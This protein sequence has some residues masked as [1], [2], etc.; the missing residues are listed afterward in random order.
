MKKLIY[1]AL[2]LAAGLFATSC[3][4]ELLEPVQGGSTVTYTVSLP[5]VATKAIGDGSQVDQL[6][7][8]VYRII[9]AK[10]LTDEKIQEAKANITE[11]CQLV[12]QESQNIKDKTVT[13][14]DLELIKNQHY[15][16]LFWAQ[17]ENVWFTH[18]TDLDDADCPN[19]G[20]FKIAYP[21]YDDYEPNNDKYDAFTGVDYISVT[22]SASADITLT[23]PFG[24]LNIATNLPDPD[25]FTPEITG[26]TVTVAGAAAASY[27]VATGV[28]TAGTLEFKSVVP[29]TSEKFKDY[30]SYL[31]MNYVFVQ[32]DPTTVTVTY[33]IATSHGNVSN[34]ITN[35]PVARNYKTNIIGNLLTSDVDYTVELQKTWGDKD[36]EVLLVDNASDLQNAIDNAQDNVETE[37][38]LDG[39][40]NL[41]DLLSAVM[42]TIKA[43]QPAHTDHGLYIPYGKSLLLDLNGCKISQ[44][45]EQ[46]SNYSMILVDGELTIIDTKGTGEISYTDSG[47]GGE[48][49]SNTIMNRG[50]LT[51]KGGKIINNSSEASADKGY[52][53]AVDSGVWGKAT[54]VIINIEGGELWSNYSPLRVRGDSPT[55][56]VEANI[57]GGK[58]YGRID[59]QLSSNNGSISI[60]NISGGEFT[61]NG[62]KEHTIK[63]FGG[64]TLNASGVV[65]N[66]TGGKFNHPFDVTSEGPVAIGQE[67]NKKFITGGE[68]A[69]DPT[70]NVPDAYKVE[71]QNGKWVVVAKP[72]VAM[73]GETGYWSLNAA[74][75]AV[76]DGGTITLVDNETFTENNRYNNGGWWDGL[77]YSG[78]KSFTIDLCGYT[79]S[80][81]G[82]LNDYLMWFKNDG[83]KANT[84]TL[85]NG[86]MDAGTTAYCALCTS[87]SNKQKI[88]INLEK[89]HL[90]NNNS[91]GATIKLRAGAELNVKAGTIITGKNSYTGIEAVGNTTIVNIYEGAKIY[92]NGTSS[93]WGFLAGASWG[94][95]INVYGGE[96]VSARGGFM[97]MTSGGTINVA[98]GKWI[99]NTDGTVGDN[100]NVY[101]LTAQ[102]NKYESGYVGASII[103]VTGGTFR[104]G[105]DAWILND[106]NVE[107]AELNIMG[108]N[109]NANPS[110]YVANDYTAVENN[111][112]WNVAVDPA[113]K[114]GET[115]YATLQ[116]ALNV[117]GNV[118]L[119]RDVNVAEPLILPKGKTAL[120]DLNGRSI[121]G[122]N[123]SDVKH[124]YALKN[125]GTLTIVDNTDNKEGSIDSRGIYNYNKL[126]LESGKISAID[127]NGGYAVNNQSGS[128]FVMNG[129][130]IAAD[131]EDDDAPGDGYDATALNVPSGAEATLNAGKITNAGNF[132]Y[133]VA[134]AGTLNIPET[135]T[136]EI[137]GRHGAVSVSGGTTTI[138]AGTY[139]IVENTQYSDNVLYVYSTGTMIING[140]TFTGDKDVANGGAC[141]YDA[142]GGVIINGGIFGNSSGGDVWGTTGTVIKG[143]KFEN[144]TE[145]SHIADGYELNA[146]GEVVAK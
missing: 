36:Y 92:Q 111:G 110:A 21:S 126:T 22:S 74:V 75:A 55:E 4:Q 51:V 98:G 140:G 77:G 37:I 40:I 12:Y 80:Q 134:A 81:D 143:G 127:G 61:K 64:S 56:K 95:T 5:E 83:D 6:V 145:T 32:S 97:A 142:I 107:K 66:I 138:N 1:C 33:N 2:A 109:F 25:L 123:E 146:N 7:Y 124:I 79:I 3:Q 101:V 131:Y 103:N 54:E 86:T 44:T 87:S 41:D 125:Y 139:G 82:A 52:M 90:I 128:T 69:F 27:N 8:A 24:Q 46:T 14:V 29:I 85:K 39:D 16:V 94:A 11:K 99:A 104:G 141:V 84:I 50:T 49:V 88:T 43:A 68:F 121:K 78:D 72:A 65:L 35:V 62:I 47:I 108:G 118:T 71:K 113:A 38:K 20:E 96:G 89:I 70:A 102:N 19:L 91:S 116:E 135:S 112:I 28:G 57:T 120:L 136:I 34:T 115:E 105:M 23:R 13:T 132:T 137:I 42:P 18:T 59:H 10:D 26:T 100:S 60:L 31:S 119:L 45:F 67:F 106:V 144:L 114:I 58:F 73:I 30:D 129:G 48:Y 93:Q 76:E 133:A 9:D 63:V 17:K 130:W 15:I 122:A 53:Y 117:G